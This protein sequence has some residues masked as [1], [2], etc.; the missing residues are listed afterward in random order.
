MKILFHFELLRF[1]NLIAASS[2]A[3]AGLKCHSSVAA[4]DLRDWFYH[5]IPG[6]LHMSV[7]KRTLMMIMMLCQSGWQTFLKSTIW[8][9]IC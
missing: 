8:V 1:M 2:S 4:V 7:M 3:V 5:T 6:G 9:Q